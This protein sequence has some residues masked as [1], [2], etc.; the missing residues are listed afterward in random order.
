[1]PQMVIEIRCGCCDFKVGEAT[2][3]KDIPKAIICPKCKVAGMPA[4][5]QQFLKT[6]KRNYPDEYFENQ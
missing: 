2:K 1:M 3:I 4:N 6:H 5:L